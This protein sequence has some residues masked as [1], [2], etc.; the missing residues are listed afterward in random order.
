MVI[1][2]PPAGLAHTYAEFDLDLGNALQD[3]AGFI[4]HTG[5]L[6]DG[7]PTN[8]LDLR[9]SLAKTKAKDFLYYTLSAA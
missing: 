8:H 5:E 1:A 4:V 7:K 3:I 2:T 6:L 9:K